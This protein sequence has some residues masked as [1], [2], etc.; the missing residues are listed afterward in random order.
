MRIAVIGATGHIGTW[1]AK[2]KEDA[3]AAHLVNLIE[4]HPRWELYDTKSDPYELT[5][6]IDHGVHDKRVKRLKAELLEW[7][8]AQGDEAAELA[9]KE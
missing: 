8:K 4:R 5:N 6:L 9:A 2:A 1:T 3:T 7:M